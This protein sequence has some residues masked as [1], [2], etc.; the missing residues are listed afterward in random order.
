MWPFDGAPIAERVRNL[1]GRPAQAAAE[2]LNAAAPAVA[3]D[4]GSQ[5]LLGT[6]REKKH[7]T[8]GGGKRLTRRRKSHKKTHRRKH[9]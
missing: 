3:T 6:G 4:A 1:I 2:P 9:H 7:Y 5:K 8:M